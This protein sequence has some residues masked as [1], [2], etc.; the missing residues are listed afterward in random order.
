M[1]KSPEKTKRPM[2]KNVAKSKAQSANKAIDRL[3]TSR[4]A[5]AKP[6]KAAPAKASPKAKYN[7]TVNEGKKPEG[8]RMSPKIAEQK[9]D[10]AGRAIDRLKNRRAMDAKMKA[11]AAENGKPGKGKV[12]YSI[13]PSAAEAFKEGSAR[14]NA[15]GSL[16]SR[17]MR[18]IVGNK[19]LVGMGAGAIIGMLAPDLYED[20]TSAEKEYKERKSARE[21]RG[22]APQG[23]VQDYYRDKNPTPQRRAEDN[24]FDSEAPDKGINPN[25][26]PQAGPG[27]SEIERSLPSAETTNVSARSV[28]ANASASNPVD[29]AQ[30]KG[31]LYPI[32]SKGSE[33]SQSFQEEF[34]KHK[35]TG[36]DFEWQ[37]RKYNSK[38]KGE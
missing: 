25:Y 3:K 1:A 30:T 2:S 17:D 22:E 7:Y 5:A 27:R 15:P 11:P 6:A 13:K 23:R 14:V 24:N 9:A 8:R 29:G 34:K 26:S 12:N 31:G 4:A 20:V 38:S 21:I 35:G 28:R 32:Y 19:A 36:K 16:A 37:G 18:G 33:E 10:S